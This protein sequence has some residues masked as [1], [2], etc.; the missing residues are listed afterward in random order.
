MRD[1]CCIL[2]DATV[3]AAAGSGS[4]HLEQ[5]LLLLAVCRRRRRCCCLLLLAEA[6]SSSKLGGWQDL[7]EIET[8]LQLILGA[9]RHNAEPT[10][11]AVSGTQNRF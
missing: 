8:G 10:Q 3:G 7:S 11:T 5:V 9:K 2:N 6:A 4:G 1:A